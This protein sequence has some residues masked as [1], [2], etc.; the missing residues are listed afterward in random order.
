MSSCRRW[1]GLGS[2]R[3]NLSTTADGS[4][5]LLELRGRD[6]AELLPAQHA[7]Q[8]DQEERR[9]HQ[10]PVSIEGRIQQLTADTAPGDQRGDEH[11]GIGNSSQHAT[12]AG[13][14]ASLLD[15]P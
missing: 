8:L 1:P 7:V 3:D 6:P 12:Q 5:E 15:V 10:S 11:V 14:G 9:Y 13:L 4:D 2:I